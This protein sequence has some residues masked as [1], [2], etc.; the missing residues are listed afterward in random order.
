MSSAPIIYP[1]PDEKAIAAMTKIW[2]RHRLEPY[3][4]RWENAYIPTIPEG[5]F[6]FSWRACDVGCGF[7]K[8]LIRESARYRERGYLGID[9]GRLRGGHMVNRFQRTGR[10]NL[11]GLHGNA[12]PIL[13]AFPDA[14]LDQITLFY[15]NPWWPPKHRKKR[16]SYHPLLPK[17]IRLLKPG[18]T[19]LLTSNEPFYLGEWIYALEH[20]PHLQG[21]ERQYVGPVAVLE[22]RSHFETKFLRENTPCGEVRYRKKKD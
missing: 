16:W 11:F 22:G 17:L 10:P 2:S 1:P 5:F 20:H 7:G 21:L 9:K 14:A 3:L 6:D 19:I 18:G 15:P 13:A 8:Y 12:I 4:R